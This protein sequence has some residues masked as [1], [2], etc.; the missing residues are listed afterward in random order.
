MRPSFHFIKA[1]VMS[2]TGQRTYGSTFWKAVSSA[3][4]PLMIML[5]WG[6]NNSLWSFTSQH[7]HCRNR[8]RLI[9]KIFKF[10]KPIFKLNFYLFW[11]IINLLEQCYGENDTFAERHPERRPHPVESTSYYQDRWVYL[12]YY[13]EGRYN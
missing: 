3:Q 12:R 6:V 13:L 8:L 9:D 5:G 10:K 4:R 2:F 7:K 11:M 1:N